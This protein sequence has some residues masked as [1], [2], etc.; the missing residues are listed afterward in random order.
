MSDTND[1][2][3][4][5]YRK[6]LQQKKN[7][8]PDSKESVLSDYTNTKLDKGTKER[9]TLEAMPEDQRNRDAERIAYDKLME[10]S[11]CLKTIANNIKDKG[12]L[13]QE[14]KVQKEIILGTDAFIEYLQPLVDDKW[15][16][17]NWTNS[18]EQV[19]SHLNKDNHWTEDP[20]FVREYRYQIFGDGTVTN[21]HPYT[22]EHILGGSIIPKI[23]KI[24]KIA[25]CFPL[26][27]ALWKNDSRT[28]YQQIRKREN[29]RSEKRGKKKNGKN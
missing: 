5:Q 18:F 8:E 11:G 2:P 27:S 1:S 9:T 24:I 6:R 22:S 10:L 20:E 26:F 21:K 16:Q 15:T 7:K 17:G 4:N 25:D 23:N 3:M 28:R 29:E 14:P 12:F 19:V 13:S